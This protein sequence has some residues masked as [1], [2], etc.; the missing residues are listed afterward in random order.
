MTGS[1]RWRLYA[2][3]VSILLSSF[4]VGSEEGQGFQRSPDLAR[5]SLAVPSGTDVNRKEPNALG[6]AGQL[7]I[8]PYQSEAVTSSSGMLPGLLGGIPN[9][10]FGYVYA[11]WTQ[12]ETSLP[13][14]GL[15]PAH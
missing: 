9:V 13:E 7:L 6:P 8:R 3:F 15:S 12:L 14:P 5:S 4:P 2:L 11:Y 1:Q 10:K